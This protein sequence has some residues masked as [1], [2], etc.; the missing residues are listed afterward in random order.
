MIKPEQLFKLPIDVKR[1]K[2]R[3][4]PK[5]TREQMLEFENKFQSMTNK[6]TFK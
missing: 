1:K 6:K 4:K 5:S 2:E 3:D